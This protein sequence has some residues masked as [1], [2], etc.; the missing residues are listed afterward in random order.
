[1]VRALLIAAAIALLGC[2][3]Q[4]RGR[5]ATARDSQLVTPTTKAAAHASL[6]CAAC[7]RGKKADVGRA[8]VPREACTASGCHEDAG[9]PQVTLATARFEHR[10]HGVNSGITLNCAGCHTH[11]NGEAVLHASLDACALCHTKKLDGT[12]SGD[13]RLCHGQ[14]RNVSY[15]SQGVPIAHASLPWMETGCA[16]CHYDVL[17]RESKVS[18]EKCSNCHAQTAAVTAS[19][20]A[21]DLHPSHRGV[22]CTSCHDAGLHRIGAMSSAVNLQCADCHDRAHDAPTADVK[23][24]G[25]CGAC[26]GDVHTAQQRLVLGIVQNEPVMPSAKFL[27]GLTCKSCHQPPGSAQ[28]QTPHAG[29]ASACTACHEPEFSKIMDWWITGVRSRGQAVQAYVTVAHQVLPVNDSM[30]ALLGNADSML[31]AVR[32]GGG[33]HNVELSDLIFRTSV[34]NVLHAYQLSG[35]TAPPAPVLGNPAKAGT[36]SFCHYATT[37]NWNFRAIPPG[38]H[39]RLIKVRK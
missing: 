38:L 18:V 23:G 30:R 24:T 22:N 4:P 34:A 26:H 6:T 37:E 17:A 12:K 28:S 27:L 19:G 15:T 31:A 32:A 33:E 13:C 5:V 16:R 25:V 11:E 36:C 21:R 20:I 10:N 8:S 39:E 7:H 1:M 3:D 29:Q 35:R 2:T 9:P 14:P